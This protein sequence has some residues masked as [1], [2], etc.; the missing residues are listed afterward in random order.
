M[1][2]LIQTN[3][4]AVGRTMRRLFKDQLP[5][6]MS[7]AINA[8]AKQAQAVQRSRQRRVFDV[9]DR[10]FMDRAVK[11]KPFATKRKPEAVIQVDPPGGESRR[12]V[13]TRHEESGV[14]R[15]IDGGS[16]AVPGDWLQKRRTSRGVRKSLRPGNL[17]L[18]QV[19]P[20]MAQGDRRTYRVSTPKRPELD[21]L[22][23]QRVGR[24]KRSTSRVLYFLRPMTPVDRRLK[25]GETVYRIVDER[26]DRNFDRQFTRAVRTAR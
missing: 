12:S 3:T 16:L 13:V 19:H 18:R 5:F 26:F 15:A 17:N 20:N 1:A 2:Q 6:A 23:L 25:F 8:T 9:R 14:R 22:I 7:Q 4:E 21:G 11:I 10:R 24:G